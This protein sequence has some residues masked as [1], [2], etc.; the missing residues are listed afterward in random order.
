[1]PH[2]FVVGAFEPGDDD[3]GDFMLDIW[4]PFARD[5]CNWVD[6]RA[7]SL[8]TLPDIQLWTHRGTVGTPE[9]PYF[10]IRTHA[11]HLMLFTGDDVD[12]TQEVFDQPN[13]PANAPANT[14]FT[15]GAGN[16]NVGSNARHLLVNNITGPYQ[17]YW[18]FCDTTGEYIHCV[19]KV[20]AREYRH[21]HIGR[22]RQIDGGVDLNA[23]S[24]YCTGHFWSSVDDG[25]SWP[26]APSADEEHAPY[27]R[28]QVPFRNRAGTSANGAFGVAMS[29]TVP[30]AYYYMPDLY[31]IQVAS[32]TVF[33]GGTGHA[34]NDQITVNFTDEDQ[35]DGVYTGSGTAAVLNVDAESG[36][37]I[38]AVSVLT[39]GPYDRATGT[40]E[41]NPVVGQNSTTGSG[42][43]AEFTLVFEGYKF[44]QSAPGDTLLHTNNFAQKAGDGG[45]SSAI[46]DVMVRS[47]I[48]G[49]QTNFYDAG[50]GTVLFACDRNFTANA[51]VLVP[52]YLAAQFDF[53]SDIRLGV[54]AQVPDIFR[55][56][57]RDY[58]P[59]ET[60]TVQGNDYKV[61]PM[62]N[63]D[64]NN[65]IDGEG[66]SGYEGLAYRVETGAVV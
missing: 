32:A 50:L 63:N 47:R 4:L 40:G 15:L 9:S 29:N 45:A 65:T 23:E 59:E 26:T 31:P 20:S 43:D 13:N 48:G 2:E 6:N 56:N 35:G 7:P 38:T 62:I 30:S 49:A 19:I 46:G 14:G 1:M 39:A 66:Y 64:S 10:F 27:G 22:L 44:F 42:V 57:M 60:I 5:V 58:S 18:L 21:F 51:N 34:V 36:G 12:L 54:V 52:I 53:Q 3:M 37:V 55:I 33:A 25:L 24:F 28:H 8:G 11:N 41:N 16:V 17:G 61:F